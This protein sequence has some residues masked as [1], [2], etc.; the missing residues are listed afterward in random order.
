MEEAPKLSYVRTFGAKSC[1]VIPKMKL[2]KPDTLSQDSMVTAYD[3]NSKGYKLWDFKPI[4]FI[5][6]PEVR[7]DEWISVRQSHQLVQNETSLLESASEPDTNGS[8]NELA[9]AEGASDTAD[10][11]EEANQ[12]PSEINQTSDQS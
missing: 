5:I 6:S 2:K 1:Y 4:K 11:E 10:E 3:P 8:G 7:L 12:I 9:Q